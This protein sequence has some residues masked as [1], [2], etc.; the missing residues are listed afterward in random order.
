[1][2]DR[3]LG[4][5]RFFLH[6]PMLS[7]AGAAGAAIAALLFV[8]LPAATHASNSSQV[9]VA[10][11]AILAGETIPVLSHAQLL[12]GSRR[13]GMDLKQQLTLTV[14]LNR[15][16]QSG[17]NHY[18]SQVMD[19]ASPTHGRYLTQA[20]LSARFGPAQSAYNKVLAWLESQGLELVQGSGDRLTITVRGDRRQAQAAFATPIRDFTV[21]G[22]RIYANAKPPSVPQ[23][24]SADIASVSGLSDLAIPQPLEETRS[25]LRGGSATTGGGTPAREFKASLLDRLAHTF[26]AAERRSPRL[27]AAASRVA[28]MLASFEGGIRP[29]Q[30]S[31]LVRSSDWKQV[32]PEVSHLAAAEGIGSAGSPRNSTVRGGVPEETSNQRSG[33]QQTG[34]P[35]GKFCIKVGSCIYWTGNSKC[36]EELFKNFAI[37]GFIPGYATPFIIATIALFLEIEVALIATPVAI[38]GAL[39]AA[40]ALYGCISIA[41][42]WNGQYLFHHTASGSSTIRGGARGLLPQKIGLLEFDGFHVS[43]VRNWMSLM[44]LHSPNLA[45]QLSVVHVNGGVSTL[46]AGESEVLID[47]DTSLALDPY[48]DYTVYEAPS[49]TSSSRYSTPWCRITRA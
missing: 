33:A 26:R 7:R 4:S 14:T 35:Q 30:L 21:G 24:L 29:E 28:R 17:F 10:G 2:L 22:R 41:I 18:L 11:R 5:V 44:G 36:F 3:G 46:G 31:R 16:D 25:L 20:Q 19:P 8:S 37:S 1:M 32:G 43:D 48:A 38:V 15:T 12:P 49:G 42:T 34:Y 13:A 39:G 6:T 23:S 45:R 40:W 9:S 27:H 47:V